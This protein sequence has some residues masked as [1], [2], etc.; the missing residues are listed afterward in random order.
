MLFFFRVDGSLKIGTGHVMRCLTLAK[1][2][3]DRGA[4]CTF[5]CREHEG[6]LIDKIRLEGFQCIALA[7]SSV[8]DTM[9]HAD[10]KVLAHADWLGASWQHDAQQ[11]I[12]VLESE[13]VDWLVSDHYAL[14]ARWHRILRPHVGHIMVIDD[15]ADRSLDCDLLLDQNIGRKEADY[16]GLVPLHCKRLIGWNF[17]LLRSEF[18]PLCASSQARNRFHSVRQILVSM[19]GMDINN[20]IIDVL[21]ALGRAN[22]P[23]NIR[24]L[25][26]ISSQAPH[27]AALQRYIKLLSF[28][29]ELHIDIDNIAQIMVESD[30]AISASGLTAYELACMGIPMILL[31][32]SEIQRTI[33]ARIKTISSATIIENWQADPVPKIAAVLNEAFSFYSA[34]NGTGENSKGC[35]DANGTRRVVQSILQRRNT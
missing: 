13:K 9:H 12:Q 16:D 33:A 5:I 32:V 10:R 31:P 30:L 2:L 34:N 28:S 4:N 1:A 8:I 17:V 26:V 18:A 14:D 19:G 20:N 27:L 24:V 7:K 25:V 21:N 15:L 11:T 3:R 22:L 23:E 35:I 6:N 29:V